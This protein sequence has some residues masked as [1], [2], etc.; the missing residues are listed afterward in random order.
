MHEKHVPRREWEGSVDD[1]LRHN[2]GVILTGAA[3]IGKSTLARHLL[4]KRPNSL[5]LNLAAPEDRQKIDSNPSLFLQSHRERTVCLDGMRWSSEMVPLLKR[6]LERDGRSGRFLLI[7]SS[8]PKRG[9]REGQ[10][11]GDRMARVELPPLTL[12][13]TSPFASPADHWLKGGYPHSLLSDP[14]ESMDWRLGHLRG[15]PDERLLKMLAHSPS[16]FLNF[17][18]LSE[19][20]GVSHHGVR[21]GIDI[22][23]R[24]FL[25]RTLPPFLPHTKKRLLK[26][27]KVTIRDSGLLHALWGIGGMDDLLRHPRLDCSFESYVLENV[28]SRHAGWTPH[29]YRDSSG[30]EIDLLLRKGDELVAIAIAA[31]AA[32]RVERG[33]WNACRFLKPDRTFVIARVKA[34][35]TGPNGSRITNLPH[36]LEHFP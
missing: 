1:L 9:R 11:W 24:A 36:F 14:R 5:Y 17:S 35:R 31:P 8:P 4:A 25:I 23:K 22:L 26:S 15:V 6:E 10:V 28:L 20:L 29:F 16:R 2:P 18:R 19:K 33:Y 7:P 12:Q 13:E 3:Q 27:P 30:N 34:P 21:S 32:P